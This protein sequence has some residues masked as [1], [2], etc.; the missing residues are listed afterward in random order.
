MAFNMN[1]PQ[2][3]VGTSYTG[4][5]SYVNFTMPNT[6]AY[7][8]QYGLY[9]RFVNNE[10]EARNMPN[11]ISGCAFYVLDNENSNPVIFAKY[12]DGRPME[13]YDMVLRENSGNS[14]Y[15]TVDAFN[16]IFDEKMNEMSRKFVLRR[17]KNAQ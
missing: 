3:S 1:V 13:T 5:Q 10:Q 11:P 2:Q 9:T 17:D 16:K 7:S 12:A 6:P 14:E 8:T 15:L 4:P